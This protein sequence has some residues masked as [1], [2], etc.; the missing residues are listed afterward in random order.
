M[1]VERGY[2]KDRNNIDFSINNK[3][4]KLNGVKQPD[5]LHEELI[6]KFIKTPGDQISWSY[7]RHK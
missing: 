5:A 2:V 7:S 4:L 6:R 3:S 1:L